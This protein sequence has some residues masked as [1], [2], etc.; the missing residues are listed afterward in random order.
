MDLVIEH[1]P[2]ETAAQGQSVEDRAVGDDLEFEGTGDEEL[3]HL[4]DGIGNRIRSARLRGEDPD[5]FERELTGL[6]VDEGG[7]DPGA[8]MSMPMAKR[9]GVSSVI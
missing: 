6:G 7:L 8:P 3:D 9:A 4:G 1:D 2:R 5:A